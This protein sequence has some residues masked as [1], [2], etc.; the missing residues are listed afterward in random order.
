MAFLLADEIPEAFNELK[1]HLPE[2]ARE[3]TD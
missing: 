3:V 1:S 2:E